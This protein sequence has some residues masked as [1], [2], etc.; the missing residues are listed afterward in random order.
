MRMPQGAL[1]ADVEVLSEAD[2]AAE[3]LVT[4]AALANMKATELIAAAKKLGVE[5]TQQEELSAVIQKILTAQADEQ[6][7]IWA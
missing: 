5:A 7:Q 6:G 3:G 4:F 2:L 1:P